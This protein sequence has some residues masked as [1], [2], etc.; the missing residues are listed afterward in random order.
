MRSPRPAA[1]DVVLAGGATELLGP[2]G[3]LG[4]RVGTAALAGVR[5][6]HR[7]RCGLTGCV[8]PWPSRGRWR[9][10]AAS[11][12]FMLRDGLTFS[13]GSPLD[14]EDVRRSWLRV[15]DPEQPSPLA[16]LL[17]DVAGAAER[18]RGTGQRG[19]GRHP[20][21]R[22]DADRGVRAP[23]LLLPG[24]RRRAH[25]GRGARAASMRWPRVREA[26]R[27]F[28]ASGPTCPLEATPS[29]VVLRGQRGLLGGPAAH[30]SH[31]R[32][33]RHRRPQRGRRLRG[34]GR[35]L[36]AHLARRRGLDPLRPAPRTPAAARATRWSSSTSASTPPSHPSTMRPSD[37]PWPWPW[38]GGAWH[39]RE[40]RAVTRPCHLASCRRASP[41]AATTD[42]LPAHDPDGR[43]C[44]PGGSRLPGRGRL[45][46]RLPG[47][48][49]RRSGGRHRPRA[50]ARAGH[51]RRGGGVV[52]RRP[53]RH[54]RGRYAGPV[55]AGLERR[56]SPRPRLPR[57][58]AA[59]RQRRQRGRLVERRLRR[60]HRARPRPRR[61]RPS[62]SASTVRHRP[63]CAT[64]CRSS[65]WATG[66]PGR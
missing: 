43:S 36:D 22:P 29:E 55:D 5:R 32:R 16:S 44:R 42:Y 47:H 52:V 57:A 20:R 10:T 2:R 46:A 38:T 25:P 66:A 1:S 49:R 61:T 14:A 3:H 8:P 54:P 39:G 9:T 27:P 48:L 34:R 18:A 23:R 33:H 51:R 60:P 4:F 58:A 6:P 19:A 28:P 30:P 12:V 15:L 64:R 40:R 59:Q 65:R 11:I 56:L 45:P 37:A 7:A 31:H 26:D 62:R 21:R 24:R 50:G 35:R 41:V 63:S 17:D 53:R 13:D